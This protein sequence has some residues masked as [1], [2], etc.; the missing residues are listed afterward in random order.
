MVGIGGPGM[1]WL[2]SHP[3]KPYNGSSLSNPPM[4]REKVPPMYKMVGKQIAYIN[5]AVWTQW[6]SRDALWSTPYAAPR[7]KNGINPNQPKFRQPSPGAVTHMEVMQS[8][9]YKSPC[10][11]PHC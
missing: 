11:A 10:A 4:Y 6:E 9:L 1:R 3:K 2:I 7:G 8:S 5:V